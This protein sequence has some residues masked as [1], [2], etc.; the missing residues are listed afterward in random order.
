MQDYIPALPAPEEIP[1]TIPPEPVVFTETDLQ[2]NPC[3]TV[4]S[5]C[6]GDYHR[7]PVERGRTGVATDTGVHDPAGH[8]DCHSP[9]DV[10][11]R[12]GWFRTVG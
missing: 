4:C 2:D 6:A 7:C 9:G 11:V 3:T 12:Y 10:V 5:D 1:Q 8:F